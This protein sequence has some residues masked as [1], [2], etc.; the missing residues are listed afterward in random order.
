MP[1]VGL[2]LANPK[3]AHLV[4]HLRVESSLQSNARTLGKSFIRLV[5]LNRR[6]QR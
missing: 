6:P 1:D 4:R 2:W 3:Q 5:Y